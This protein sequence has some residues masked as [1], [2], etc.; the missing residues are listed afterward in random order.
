MYARMVT[1]RV[2]PH[3]LDEMT[4]FYRNT[5][6]PLLNCQPGC[7][8]FFVLNNLEAQEEVTITFW[9]NLTDMEGFN[10]NL[11]PLKDKIASLL[12]EVPEVQILRV[13]LP[14]DVH[15]LGMVSLSEAAL[16]LRTE[17]PF[18]RS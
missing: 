13:A 17:D 6:R 3:K 11:A 7:K 9:E 18:S 4:A 8:G 2:K 1:S 16:G 12:A 15:P 5:L 10:V 14:E